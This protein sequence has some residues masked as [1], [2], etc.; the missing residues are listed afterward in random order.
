M[1]TNESFDTL[2]YAYLAI[3]E[4]EAKEAREQARELFNIHQKELDAIRA[5]RATRPERKAEIAAKEKASKAAE[6][7]RLA[8]KEQEER[9]EWTRVL[10]ALGHHGDSVFTTEGYTH[11]VVRATQLDAYG[12]FDHFTTLPKT[13]TPSKCIS[14]SPPITW[15]Y[16]GYEI[17]LMIDNGE[18][19]IFR[20]D[21]TSP[22]ERKLFVE[23]NCVGILKFYEHE[24][25]R[26][27]PT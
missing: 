1:P 24:D 12:R 26:F 7:T 21:S 19:M 17:F 15:A 2:S 10:F 25:P 16:R 22:D 23:T 27:T 8:A 11:Q 4:Q 6:E 9:D 3:R 5:E 13:S 14:M 20:L 18:L